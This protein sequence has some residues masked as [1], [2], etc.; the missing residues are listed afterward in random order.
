[1]FFLRNT[2]TI[3]LISSKCIVRFFI[4]ASEKNSKDIPVNIGFLDIKKDSM[5]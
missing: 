2:S 4:L 1:M 5:S 3:E